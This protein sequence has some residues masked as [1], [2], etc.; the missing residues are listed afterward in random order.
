MLKILIADDHAVVRRGLAQILSETSDANDFHKAE[1][2]NEVLNK[3]RKYNYDVVVLDISMPGRSG[4]EIIEQIKIEKPKLPV[5]ILSVHPEE[6]YAVRVLKSGAAGYLNKA[7]VPEE[8]VSAIR[9]VAQGGKYI[10]PAMAER[11]AWHLESEVKQPIHESLSDREYQ[12]MLMIAEG[13]TIG[14]IADELCLSVKTISTYR[15][16]VLGKM[17]MTNNAQLTRYAVENSLLD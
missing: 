11:L 4:L 7:S 1:N 16:R 14:K 8:L 13:K 2:G 5:L 6:Q 3:I 12:V 15:T 17:K 10:S 9:R